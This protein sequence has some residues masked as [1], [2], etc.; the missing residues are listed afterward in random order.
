MNIL[1]CFFFS[2]L[3]IAQVHVANLFGED[4]LSF[5]DRVLFTES[6]LDQVKQ[7]TC[8]SF[9]SLRAL[10]LKDGARETTFFLPC[11]WM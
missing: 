2:P 7:F 4:K 6:H 3:L 11:V 1:P 5:D 10:D 9:C 8:Q